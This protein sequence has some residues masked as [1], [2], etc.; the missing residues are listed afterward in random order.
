MGLLPNMKSSLFYSYRGEFK[1]RWT[2]NERRSLFCQLNANAND[3]LLWVNE[4]YPGKLYQT[5][6]LCS[7]A[8]YDWFLVLEQTFWEQ[9]TWQMTVWVI[10]SNPKFCYCVV[11]WPC[12]SFAYML[13]TSLSWSNHVLIDSYIGFTGYYPSNWILG[14]RPNTEWFDQIWFDFESR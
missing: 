7:W 3:S 5:S 4:Q 10:V 6:C 9:W 14:A 2:K 12:Y 11:L 1:V 13:P 8:G